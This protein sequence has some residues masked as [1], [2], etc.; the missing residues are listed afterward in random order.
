[1]NRASGSLTRKGFMDLL[2]DEVIRKGLCTVC[3]A[4][5]GV[6]PRGALRINDLI[7]ELTGECD[8]C[9]TCY[10]SCPGKNIH[11]DRLEARIFGRSRQAHEK[12][13]GIHAGCFA[14]HSAESFIRKNA[15]S[16]GV[17]TALLAYAFDRGLIDGALI[18]GMDPLNPLSPVPMLAA[19]RK[20]LIAGQKSKYMLVSGGLLSI[21]KE[22]VVDK[23]FK[24][25]AVVGSA[26]HIHAI[27][28]IQHSDSKFLRV[29]IGAKIKYAIGLFCAFNFFPEGTHAIIQ[30]LGLK[31]E[32]LES[33]DWRDTSE[34]PFPGKFCA[35]TK[36][37]EKRCMDLLQEYIILG[38]IFDHPRCR[39]C[40][41]WANEL[42][43]ISSG[44]EVDEM[45]FHRQGSKRSHTVVRTTAGRTLFDGAVSGGYLESEK[46]SED[47]IARN[48]GFVIK[49]IGNIPRIE[50]R[51]KL[52]LPL[53]EYGNYPFY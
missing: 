46:T 24:N 18:T 45:G 29:S 33:I 36:S 38:G 40:Y 31:P 50:E 13:I 22:I 4:C 7:P 17:I 47:H 32:E 3:G 11:L 51:R 27:R 8:G 25:I 1:M 6:C 53:P 2:N 15:T 14:A 10:E 30:A 49:K 21:L 48:L 23:G 43:D 5:A 42:A 26:C 16:G 19:G 52:G 9:G 44:D 41:D 39:L 35:R 12:R 34:T 37:G 28:K 20:D